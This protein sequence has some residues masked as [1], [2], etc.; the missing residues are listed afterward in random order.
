ME[1]KFF[2]WLYLSMGLVLLLFGFRKWAIE[3]RWQRALALAEQVER[4]LD[5]MP[6]TR[7]ILHGEAIEGSA[8]EEYARLAALL[9]PSAHD[10]WIQSC[11]DLEFGETESRDALLAEHSEFWEVLSRGARS[12]DARYSVDWKLGARVQTPRLMDDLSLIHI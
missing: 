11:K 10:D 6:S 3:D 4:E 7:P 1:K 9:Q 5:S 12:V 2:R 8:F